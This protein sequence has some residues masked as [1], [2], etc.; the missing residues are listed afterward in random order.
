[1]KISIALDIA[2]QLLDGKTLTAKQIALKHEISCRT[3]YRYLDEIS[4]VLPIWVER[5]C[6]GG[7]KLLK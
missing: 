3:V 1:M 2:L 7:V 4:L 5:G 6:K